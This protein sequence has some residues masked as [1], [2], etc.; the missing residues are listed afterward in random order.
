[1]L[2]VQSGVLDHLLHPS[3]QKRITDSRMYGN[4]YELTAVMNDLTSAIF[5]GDLRGPTNTFRQNL[6]LEYVAKLLTMVTGDSKAAYDNIAQ[7]NALDSLRQVEAMM[8]ANPGGDPETRAHRSNVLFR[9][10]QGLSNDG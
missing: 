8:R 4:E 3:V 10:E 2:S 7:S 1:M 5:T 9:I 6:Q